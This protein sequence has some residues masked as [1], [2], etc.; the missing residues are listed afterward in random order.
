MNTT[1]TY[2]LK[3][4]DQY[5][6]SLDEC[7]ESLNY[8]LSYDADYAPAL[9]LMGRIYT[10]E[11]KNYSMAED[12]YT[13]A[14]AADFEYSETYI[15]YAKLLLILDRQDELSVLLDSAL[16]VPG[17]DKSTV[18]HVKALSYEYQGKFGET[19]DHLYRAL[20]LSYNS[21]TDEFLL[22]EIKRVQGKQKKFNKKKK[23]APQ[24]EPKG[25]WVKTYSY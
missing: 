1:E 25:Q 2:F 3:A 13:R 23:K 20:K 4:L 7:I 18:Y 24:P 14:L 8:A 12:F 10:M 16:K 6:D 5:A 17:M 19:L 11:V 15:Y 21:E 22:S 9:C